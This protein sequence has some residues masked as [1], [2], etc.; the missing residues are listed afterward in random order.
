MIDMK[1]IYW[2]AGYLEGEGSFTINRRTNT[3]KTFRLVVN[4]TDKDVIA[5]VGN[6]IGSRIHRHNGK[7]WYRIGNKQPFSVCVVNRKAIGWMMTLYPL[8][9]ERRKARIKE[10]ILEWRNHSNREQK[11]FRD[12]HKQVI[13]PFVTKGMGVE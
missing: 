5:K 13:N 4:S 2:L 9:G 12:P 6:L 8:M 11:A 10:I 1:D 7:N 3:N